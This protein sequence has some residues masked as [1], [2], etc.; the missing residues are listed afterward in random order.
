[1][2]LLLPVFHRP[3]LLALAAVFTAPLCARSIKDLKYPHPLPVYITAVTTF[4]ERPDWSRDGKRIVFVEKTVGDIFEVD[5]AFKASQGV[6]S[7]DGQYMAFQIS[8][9]TDE[10]G[11]GYGIM[12]MDVP[13]FLASRGLRLPGDR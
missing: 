8:K 12:V 9:T 13:A 10:T 3:S 7:P 1:M 11:Y 4:G 5:P 2:N 6:I